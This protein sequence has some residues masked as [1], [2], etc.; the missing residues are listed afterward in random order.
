MIDIV[1]DYHVTVIS[2][3]DL[4]ITYK[5]DFQLKADRLQTPP[6]LQTQTN[7]LDWQ[8]EGEYPWKITPDMNQLSLLQ[9]L[10]VKLLSLMTECYLQTGKRSTLHVRSFFIKQ[11]GLSFHLFFLNGC[12]VSEDTVPKNG[13]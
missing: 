2:L 1:H 3:H 6:D 5:P 10:L 4:A 7:I 9:H 12:I 8:S 11:E 13:C